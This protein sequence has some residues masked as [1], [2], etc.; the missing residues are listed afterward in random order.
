MKFKFYRFISILIIVS[1]WLYNWA[2]YR[3]VLCYNR[4]KIVQNA[5]IKWKMTKYKH[6]KWGCVHTS[7]HVFVCFC[8]VSAPLLFKAWEPPQICI[9]YYNNYLSRSKG[10]LLISTRFH[11]FETEVHL[12]L[13]VISYEVKVCAHFLKVIS[14][15]ALF[16]K[17]FYCW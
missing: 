3:S 2:I 10:G 5:K 7:Q 6:I 4:V 9:S 14:Y 8:L 11:Q 16:K 1:R 17:G 12:N 15:I 13:G